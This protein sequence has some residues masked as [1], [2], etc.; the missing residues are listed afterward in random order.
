MTDAP[1]GPRI[2]PDHL[3]Q[4][5]V[6]FEDDHLLA[7]GKPAGI[8]VHG[9]A[10]EKKKTVLEVLAEAYEGKKKDLVLAHRLDRGTSGVL[11]LAKS[12]ELAQGLRKGWHHAEKVYWAVALGRLTETLRIDAPLEDK[13][14]RVLDAVTH[15]RPLAA[16][17]AVEPTTTLVEC[18]LETGRTHQIRRHLALRG[19]PVLMDDKHGRFSANK[20]WD[21]A[22]RAAGGPRPKHLMLHA[23]RLSF[24]HPVTGARLTLEAPLPEAWDRILR[25]AGADLDA[26]D[27]E[28][29]RA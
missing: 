1:S 19:H 8:A 21:K 16:L 13:E 20:Q 29:R 22:V 12:T 6:L 5:Q 17:G 26:L 10:A 4:V 2:Q 28:G 24:E 15:A 23:R 25:A 3:R 27:A 11:L 14:G 9:G 18:T 7:V